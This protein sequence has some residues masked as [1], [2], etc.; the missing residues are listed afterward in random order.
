MVNDPNAPDHAAATQDY[1][2]SNKVYDVLKFLSLILLPAVATLYFALAAIWHLP[3][4]NEVVGSIVAV[5][6][7]LGV[8]VK[9]STNSYNNSEGK[10]DGSIIVTSDP[11]DA[12]KRMV[13]APK[14]DIYDIDQKDQVT[15]KV[16]SQ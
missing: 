6:T 3:A 13:L 16:E 14:G 15:L 9:F 12:S 1:A 10:Y 7:F 2:I 11:A 8:L 5:D 4:A